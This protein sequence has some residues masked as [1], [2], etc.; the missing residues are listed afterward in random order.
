[1]KK[2]FIK[3]ISILL[4]VTV[5]FGVTPHSAAAFGLPDSTDISI[6]ALNVVNY[7]LSGILSMENAL[8]ALLGKMADTVMQPQ[9]MLSAPIVLKGWGITRD[10]ANMFFILILLAI[11]LSFILFPRFQIKQALPRLLLVALLI[12]FSLPIAGIFIDFANIFTSYFLG[13]AASGSN[14]SEIIAEKV[15]LSNIYDLTTTQPS[16]EVKLDLAQQA[17]KTQLFGIFF[18]G[19]MIFI[20]LALGVMFLLRTAWLY[21]LLILMP[22]V[23][24]ISV[25]PAGKSYFSQWSHKFFQWTFF[26]PISTFFLFL[27]V[28]L[29]NDILIGSSSKDAMAQVASPIGVN[30]L[31]EIYNYITITMLLLG[32]LAAGNALGVKT[33]GVTNRML[34]YGGKA[35]RGGWSGVKYGKSAIDRARERYG[36]PASQ[37]YEEEAKKSTALGGVINTFRANRLYKKS[38]RLKEKVP[39][40]LSAAEKKQ[41]ETG[42]ADLLLANINKP[43]LSARRKSE[44]EGI[45]AKRGILNS[46]NKETGE[47]DKEKTKTIVSES[48]D[49]AKRVGNKSALTALAGAHP[50]IVAEKR[51]IE[52]ESMSPVQ[53]QRTYGTGSKE[54]AKENVENFVYAQMSLEDIENKWKHASGAEK[55]IIVLRRFINGMTMKQAEALESRGQ[56]TGFTGRMDSLLK[57]NLKAF[58][59]IEQAEKILESSE[60]AKTRYEKAKRK[61]E[62]SPSR[63]INARPE[64][65]QVPEKFRKN[66]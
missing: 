17:F 24:L 50:E 20:F 28:A 49:R 62:S 25:L 23:L 43:G 38:A 16:T 45:A 8:L 26:A 13:Q 29:F 55:D 1:M 60:K 65:D 11:A 57:G 19:I 7:V 3:T 37:K 66:Q 40:V 22:M 9:P 48:Y 42:P 63:T 36:K 53:L 33:A 27:S 14:F 12:N 59:S 64:L 61:Y 54:E 4:V 18:I 44:L 5:L 58:E 52:I 31:S 34:K 21:F 47:I 56:V 41:A 30:I 10:F 46:I 32:S 35:I 6:G 2:Y 51:K 39:E 15:N